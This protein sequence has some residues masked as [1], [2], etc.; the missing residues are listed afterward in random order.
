[1]YSHVQRNILFQFYLSFLN[2]HTILTI[3][4][5]LN[6]QIKYDY[7]KHSITGGGGGG[8]VILKYVFSDIIFVK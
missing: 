5:H 8:G 7:Y 1:M 3:F 6:K 4:S 2:N